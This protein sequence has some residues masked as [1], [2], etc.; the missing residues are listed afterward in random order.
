MLDDQGVFLHHQ[1]DGPEPVGAEVV[2]QSIHR[3]V[4]LVA[5]LSL[6]F[7][8]VAPLHTHTCQRASAASGAATVEP[9]PGEAGTAT[10]HEGPCLACTLDRRLQAPVTVGVVAL[11]ALPAVANVA[12]TLPP[13]RPVGG[14][15][16]LIPPR[17][18]P[19]SS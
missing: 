18:P 1:G 19:L 6:V 17:G 13:D 15:R 14:G 7:A 8:V 10:E 9:L 12:L 16:R 11:H 4:A 3:V 5:S 2:R